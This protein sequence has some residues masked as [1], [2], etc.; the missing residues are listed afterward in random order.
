M[1]HQID[2]RKL[3][4][5]LDLFDSD[6][7]IGA[8]LPFWL[9]AGAAA[10]YEVETYLREAERRAGYQHVYSPVLGKR[11]LYERSGHWQHFGDDMFPMHGGVGGRRVRAAA[12]AVPAPRA[13]LQV[14]RP[15]LPRPA[16]AHRRNRTAVPGRTL[17]RARRPEPGPLD[18]AQRRA[19]LLRAR[20]GRRRDRR[21]PRADRAGAPGSRHPERRVS[22]CRCA[23]TREKYAGERRHVGAR[24]GTAPE[25]ARRRRG[26]LRRGAGRGGVLRAEDRRADRRPGRPRVDPLHHPGRLPPAGAVR[27]VLRGRVRCAGSGR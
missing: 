1:N 11:E 6:P 18:L 7:L 23:A 19:Q 25:G 21:D 10:R 16:A 14:A 4:R 9:P 2:H 26:V 24:R 15:L 22:G 27:P 8:G 3:G 5:E 12:V 17:R 20:P 13:D